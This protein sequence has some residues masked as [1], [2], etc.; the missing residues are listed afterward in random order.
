MFAALGRA[1]YRRRW[2]VLVAGLAFMLASGLAGTTLFGTLKAG[3]YDNPEAE[4]IR[5]VELLRKELGRDD[6]TLVVLFTST[7]GLQVDDPAY[8]T[9][10]EETLARLEGQPN[11]GRTTGYYTTG[12]AQ[13]V[14]NDRLSTYAAVGVNGDDDVQMQVMDVVRPLLTSNR[15]QVRLGGYPATAQDI[16]EQVQ[17]DLERAELLSFPV[18]FVLLV[19]V[20]GSL[21]AAAMPLFIGAFTI[22]GGL[23]L[24]RLATTVTDMSVFAVNIVTMLGLGLAIDYSLFVVSR[25][26]EEL[27]RHDNDVQAALSRTMQTA[28]RTVVFSGLTVMIS[29]LSLVIFPQ[30]LMKSLGWGGSAAVL[31][32]MLATVTVLPAALALL[33]PRV[34]RLSVKSL[35][36][37]RLRH[38]AAHP[39][40]PE[41]S[42]WY[43]AST[44]VMRY[45]V[46][47]LVLTV[48]PLALVGLPF[49]RIVISIPDHRAL[50]EGAES[51]DVGDMLVSNFPHNETT[52]IEIA[53][54]SEQSALDP[55]SIAA[56]F[57]YT[58]DI[59]ALPDVRRVDSLVNLD[60]RLDAG[61]VTAYNAFYG[62]IGKPLNPMAAQAEQAARLFAG[63]NYSMVRVVFEPGTLSVE[64]QRLV[65]SIRGMDPPGGLQTLVGGRTA[66]LIDFVDSLGRSVPVAIGLI[67]VVMFVLLFLMVGSV[68]V[69]LTAVL[70]NTLSLSASFG[71]LV[72]IFQDG[73]LADLLRFTP[74]GSIDGTMP[75]LIFATAFGLS[76]D[77]E[78]FLLSRIKEQY[79]RTGDTTQAVATG[80]QKTGAIIT[81]AAL[82]LVVV[83]SS[84]AIGEVLFMKQ[85]GVGLGLAIL[86]DA[87]LV[88]MLLVPA[89]MRLL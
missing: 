39:D 52:P 45:P 86:V 79:D 49:L 61:G 33:G 41:G 42:F 67:V 81:S 72:W 35:L 32:A 60:P 13:F 11:I 23:M 36:P 47:V 38:E 68:V 74:M 10:V 87:T 73:N 34:N 16:T 26:R 50:P 85:V 83:I 75:V 69:P 44:F 12:A 46:P 56:L 48:I 5:A 27:V 6:R 24:L 80:V 54:R 51:R 30:M 71:A 29:L 89:T 28:G 53:V 63:G 2:I 14:S 21:V 4:S 57:D 62:A 43:R 31:V 65:H 84:F 76:M 8:K 82:L 59:A 9:E 55:E 20:F 18:V 88:R 58:R 66:E 77:Y 7:D 70:L 78:V 15:L 25:F 19:I 1:V 22:L 37:G 3:G 40:N 17:R 64:S